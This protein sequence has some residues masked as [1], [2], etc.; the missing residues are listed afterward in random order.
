MQKQTIKNGKIFTKLRR[1]MND[2]ETKSQNYSTKQSLFEPFKLRNTYKN[3][4]AP[5]R[6]NV[7]RRWR[8]RSL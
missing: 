3:P 4:K 7:S 8:R 6:R 2:R 5:W 1:S